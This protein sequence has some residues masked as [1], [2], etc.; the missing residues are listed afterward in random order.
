MATWLAHRLLV[1]AQAAANASKKLNQLAVTVTC[2][3]TITGDQNS[4]AVINGSP[5][6]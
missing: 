4:I 3:E 1:L 6:L 2:K 5:L